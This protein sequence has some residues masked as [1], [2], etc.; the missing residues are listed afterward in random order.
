MIASQIAG[1]VGDSPPLASIICALLLVKAHKKDAAASLSGHDSVIE[2][3]CDPDQP[4][5][6]PPEPI[7]ARTSPISPATFEFSGSL[8]KPAHP[9]QSRFIAIVPLAKPN[10]VS[11][12]R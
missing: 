5:L 12:Q 10:P 2:K 3:E 8:K 6:K 7:G 9:A 11:S 4:V 1:R